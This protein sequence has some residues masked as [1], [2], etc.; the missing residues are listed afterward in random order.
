MKGCNL[1]RYK[2]ASKI[3]SGNESPIVQAFIAPLLLEFFLLLDFNYCLLY[4]KWVME[5][6]YLGKF[7]DM[8]EVIE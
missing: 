6:E 3:L 5:A 2:E 1:E 7:M 8:V 4:R